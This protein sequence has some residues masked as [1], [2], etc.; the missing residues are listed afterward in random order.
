LT[1]IE[2]HCNALVLG[3]KAQDLVEVNYK[4]LARGVKFRTKIRI[5]KSTIHK[6]CLF[7]KSAALISHLYSEKETRQ[8]YFSNNHKQNIVKEFET[9]K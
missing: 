1:P 5:L 3:D 7:K 6:Y 9:T 8:R 4:W 2:K